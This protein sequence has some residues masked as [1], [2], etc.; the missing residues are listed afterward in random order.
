M[1]ESGGGTHVVIVA[2]SSAAVD[3]T[4]HTP[5]GWSVGVFADIGADRV[6]WPGR[7][8]GSYCE[9]PIDLLKALPKA[10]GEP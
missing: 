10:N 6:G 8:W 5:G 9:L 7:G 4:R 2:I 1:A 3:V